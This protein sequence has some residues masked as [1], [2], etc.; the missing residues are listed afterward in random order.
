MT[1]CRSADDDLDRGLMLARHVPAVGEASDADARSDLGAGR[2]V[3][4]DLPESRV[5]RF[6]SA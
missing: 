4:Q 3:G 5:R 2:S 1:T 6:V